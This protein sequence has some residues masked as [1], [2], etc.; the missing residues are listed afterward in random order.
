MLFILQ[1]GSYLLNQE[2]DLW[3]AQ[4]S[5]NLVE[6]NPRVKSP[7]YRAVAVLGGSVGLPRAFGARERIFL[8]SR[9]FQLRPGGRL[10][11]LPPG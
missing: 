10:R 6:Q 9:Q 11:R 5:A 4:C 7:Q 3:V 2:R 8:D 1:R